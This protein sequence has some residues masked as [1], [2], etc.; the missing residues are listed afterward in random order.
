[1][2]GGLWGGSSLLCP[3]EMRLSRRWGGKL[4]ILLRCAVGSHLSLVF[5]LF[6]CLT[7]VT[8]GR[9]G[10][11]WHTFGVSLKHSGERTGTSFEGI[12][13]RTSFRIKQFEALL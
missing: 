13:C 2:G 6:L 10:E 3:E 1:M 12:L 7:A 9:E 11:V 8:D 5:R 4:Y